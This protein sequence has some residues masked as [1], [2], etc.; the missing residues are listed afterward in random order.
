MCFFLF[1]QINIVKSVCLAKM[2]SKYRLKGRVCFIAA[3][4]G[5]AGVD[6]FLW[7]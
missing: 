1:K 2:N 5:P 4:M 6:K 3:F 7:V